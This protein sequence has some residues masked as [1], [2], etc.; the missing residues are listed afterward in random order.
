MRRSGPQRG[1]RE[2]PRSTG[3]Q[4]GRRR[5][6]SDE[7]QGE[8]KR[9][10]TKRRRAGE[11]QRGRGDQ[12][13]CGQKEVKKRSRRTRTR[14][15]RATGTPGSRCS[16]SAGVKTE[17]PCGRRDGGG[18]WEAMP[19][20]RVVREGGKSEPSKAA[21][22]GRSVCQKKLG[23]GGPRA[24]ETPLCKKAL[25]DENL[26]DRASHVMRET[27]RAGSAAGATR[28]KKSLVHA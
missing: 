3:G 5:R 27:I 11:D 4:G 19:A 2:T 21:S 28:Q 26:E 18:E 1:T 9:E 12:G 20:V 22:G 14:A 7:N 6:H 10:E 8:G 15:A 25:I 13:G 23:Q 16:R 17:L 24:G